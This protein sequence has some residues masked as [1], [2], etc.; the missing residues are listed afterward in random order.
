[1]KTKE[2][3]IIVSKSMVGTITWLWLYHKST[4]I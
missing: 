3:N 1:M 2:D 4:S